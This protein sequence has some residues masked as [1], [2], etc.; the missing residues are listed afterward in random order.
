MSELDAAAADFD[1]WNPGITS[2][3]PRELLHLSTIFRPDNVFTSLETA[4]ELHGITGLP[5]CDLISFRPERL[6]LH[7]V[8]IRVTADFEVPDGMLI[9]DLGINFRKIT[10]RLLSSYVIPELPTILLAYAAA[11]QELDAAIVAV[12]ASVIPEAAAVPVRFFSRWMKRSAQ[13]ANRRDRDWGPQQ[14]ATLDRLATFATEGLQ[15]LV[16]RSLAL[17]LAALFKNPR[18]GMGNSR[19]H[20][21]V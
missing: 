17:V 8:L 16:C 10:T 2:P 13:P 14:L 21:V 18:A 3:I 4:T 20:R 6:V 1:A 19:S 12:L 5:L 9:G 7:E 11:R 15:R